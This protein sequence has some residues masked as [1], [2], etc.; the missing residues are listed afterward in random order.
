MDVILLHGALGC[1]GHWNHVLPYLDKG[2]VYHHLDF[3]LHGGLES[4]KKDL[5]R[6]DLVNFLTE[7]IHQHK[8]DEFMIM[9]YS[10][11]GYIA[12][13]LAIQHQKGLKKV[14]TL[15]TKLK[16][17]P[18]IAEEEI[19]RIGLD[20]LQPIHSKLGAE[21]GPQWKDVVFAT[22]SI[23]RSIGKNPI[24]KEEFEKIEIPAVLL[25]GEKDKMVTQ[26]ETVMFSQNGAT[27]SYEILALQPHLLERVD[28]ELLA[29]KINALLRQ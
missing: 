25:L 20:G 1:K 16:W 18:E 3:P 21:H 2:F 5:T 4:S 24:R 13:H 10:M 9:G 7:Y 19:A 26:E 23:M 12:L 17:S 27:C 29:A 6:D 8:L 15:G 11:G 14:I 28:G 22:H